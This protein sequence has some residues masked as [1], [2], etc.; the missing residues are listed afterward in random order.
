MKP[1]MNL[2]KAPEGMSLLDALKLASLALG[3]PV[4]EEEHD[5]GEL[6]ERDYDENGKPLFLL[7]DEIWE[8]LDEAGHGTPVIIHHFG[9]PNEVLIYNRYATQS[10]NVKFMNHISEALD[11]MLPVTVNGK[12]IYDLY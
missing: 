1:E 10:E 8:I 6:W 2:P 3:A 11:E 12:D 9:I 5:D 7:C 4:N